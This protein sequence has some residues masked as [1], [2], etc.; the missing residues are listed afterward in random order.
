MRARRVNVLVLRLYPHAHRRDF[1]PL[2]LQTFADYYHDTVSTRGGVGKWFWLEIL[3]DAAASASREQRSAFREGWL[4]SWI[5]RHLGV[6]AGLLLGGLAIPIIVWSNVLSPNNESDSEYTS[7]YLLGYAVLFL[8]FACI[9]FLA[10]RRTGQILPG[11]WAGAIAALLG[12]A[13]TV[14]AFFAVDNLFLGI[15]GQQVD[16][17][18]G[19]HDSTF[20]TMRAY[21]NANL[22]YLTLALPILA[23]AGAVFGTLGA[24]ARKLLLRQSPAN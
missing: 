14:A 10:S 13:I 17:L 12:G 24:A 20:P 15:V 8:V 1:G 23:G 16:K 18:Q 5:W 2:M 22:V 21:V 4:M 19:F 7:L 9:G 11:A 3:T 6:T